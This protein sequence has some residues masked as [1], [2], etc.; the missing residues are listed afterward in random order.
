MYTVC[1]N[2]LTI[3]WSYAMAITISFIWLSNK[4]VLFMREWRS[5]IESGRESS[6]AQ[7]SS[8][9]AQRNRFSLRWLLARHCRKS[10]GKHSVN[11]T[12]TNSGKLYTRDCILVCCVS[13][14]GLLGER[15][16]RLCGCTQLLIA[17]ATSYGVSACGNTDQS[18]RDSRLHLGSGR[19]A[20]VSL[21]AF[22]TIQFLAFADA[23]LYSNIILVLVLFDC[24][25]KETASIYVINECKE[26]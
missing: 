18:S 24:H 15:N 8:W 14:S 17:S 19:R 12:K 9:A 7:W 25:Y 16:A 4:D 1:I 23:I 2:K 3:R 6:I 5:G 11:K 21:Q 13:V 10:S 26:W 22:D 20:P